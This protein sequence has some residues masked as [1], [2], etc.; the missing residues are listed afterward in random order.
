[1]AKCHH[2]SLENEC[3]ICN[4]VSQKQFREAQERIK[5]LE[6][7]VLEYAEGVAFDPTWQNI[8]A[9]NKQLK[10]TNANLVTTVKGYRKQCLEDEEIKIFWHERCV[11]LEK[12]LARIRE[13]D[14]KAFKSWQKERK[15]LYEEIDA[16]RDEA[17]QWRMAME[18][19]GKASY[20]VLCRAELAEEI[21]REAY[22]CLDSDSDVIVKWNGL[23]NLLRKI[24][25]EK[26]DEK[27][28]CTCSGPY[29]AERNC[30][31]CSG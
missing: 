11:D 2:G 18:N 27:N 20:A 1:M 25:K 5:Q 31:I 4:P 22:K 6:Q 15:R 24:R 9:E 12:E 7:E 8:V 19:Q 30:P 29:F 23:I 16:A 28:I 10:V 14:G 13:L 26:Q 3:S 17:T 21:V